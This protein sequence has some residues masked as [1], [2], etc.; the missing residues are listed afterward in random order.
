MWWGNQGI[1]SVEMIGTITMIDLLIK[2]FLGSPEEESR[3]KQYTRSMIK[4]KMIISIY[5]VSVV[6]N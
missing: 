5:K 4:Y 3:T 6:A 1:L 2:S